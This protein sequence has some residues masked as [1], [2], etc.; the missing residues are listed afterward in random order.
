MR[1]KKGQIVSKSGAKTI[2]VEVHNYRA[3][4]KYKK[5]YRISN[6][7]HAHDEKGEAK[8]GDEVIIYETRP[9]SKL[10]RWTLTTPERSEGGRAQA[11]SEVK[12]PEAQ[13]SKE[14]QK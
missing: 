11:K 8:V 13:P 7:F 5:R 14:E 1:S 2:V 9:I 3:H 4:P 10:K 6:K 12:V